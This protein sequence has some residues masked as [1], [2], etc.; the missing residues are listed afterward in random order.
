MCA[1]CEG[2]FAKTIEDADFEN[3]TSLAMPMKPGL[4]SRSESPTGARKESWRK[5]AEIKSEQTTAES[6][7][8]TA[9]PNWEG[10]R[11]IA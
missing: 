6:H 7:Q 10:F 11:W 2:I 9:T 3:R 4:Y 1:Y 8:G 5:H